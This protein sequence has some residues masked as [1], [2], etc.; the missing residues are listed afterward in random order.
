MVIEA[1]LQLEGGEEALHHRIVPTAPLG[2]QAAENLSFLQQSAVVSGPVLAPLI[3]VDQQLVRLHQALAECSVES[4][5]DQVGIHPLL[6]LPAHHAAALVVDSDGEIPP[7]GCRADVGDVAGPAAVG[8]RR[9][10]LLLQ[11][12]L[13]HPHSAPPAPGA[14]PEGQAGLAPQ[15]CPPHQPSDPMATDLET[16]CDQFLVDRWRAVEAPMLTDHHLDL[17]G[18]HRVLGRQLSRRL[19]P[20]P[21]GIEAARGDAQLP[22]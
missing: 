16:G 13:C 22:A 18:E 5:D 15:L 14:G 9:P 21:P 20:L 10:K 11:Q 4:L 8:G 7:A 3:G 17:R 6:Q 1:E 12:V 2:G 19:Q